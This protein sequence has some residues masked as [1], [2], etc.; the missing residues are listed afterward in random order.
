M[1][2]RV[3]AN[4]NHTRHGG[5]TLRRSQLS[6]ARPAMRIPAGGREFRIRGS[7]VRRAHASRRVCFAHLQLTSLART[8]RASRCDVSLCGDADS[9]GSARPRPRRSERARPTSSKVHTQRQLNCEAHSLADLHESREHCCRDWERH[10]RFLWVG[11]SQLSQPQAQRSN[12]VPPSH[13]TIEGR[14]MVGRG[15][16]LVGPIA[17]ARAVVPVMR[18]C[19]GARI[20]F[21]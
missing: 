11:L 18:C 8:V 15:R 21:S 16:F 6:S 19:N 4:R 3:I 5:Q 17:A 20:L 2:V 9:R 10:G 13:V 12:G 7:G 1:H 14:G